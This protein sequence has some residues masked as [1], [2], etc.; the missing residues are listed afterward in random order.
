MGPA[1]RSDVK[2][3]GISFLK[4]GSSPLFSSFFSDN[5]PLDLVEEFPVVWVCI[6]EFKIVIL[7]KESLEEEEVSGGA[8]LNVMGL[9]VSAVFFDG[10]RAVKKAAEIE[11]DVKFFIRFDVEVLVFIRF[12]ED[13]EG[14]VAGDGVLAFID[15]FRCKQ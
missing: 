10:K 9:A 2:N 3:R 12:V 6:L 14:V 8:D 4:T 11:T 15:E 7:F 1:R 13:M 5:R